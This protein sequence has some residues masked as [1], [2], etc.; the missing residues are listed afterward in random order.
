MSYDLVIDTHI[1]NLVLNNYFNDSLDNGIPKL[2][3]EVNSKINRIIKQSESNI[4]LVVSVV[5]LIE[6]I[7]KFEIITKGGYSNEKFAAFLKDPPEWFLIENLTHEIL[8]P[9]KDIPPTVNTKIGIEKIEW[10]DSL[11]LATA[12]LRDSAKLVTFDHKLLAIDGLKNFLI[13]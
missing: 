3:K 2:S 10:M 4:Y 5:A 7:R 13:S 12:M 11:H 9:M 6:L 1:L 8:V